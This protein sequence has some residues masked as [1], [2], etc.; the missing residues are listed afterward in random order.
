MSAA[1]EL[2]PRVVVGSDAVELRVDLLADYSPDS[3]GT[4]IAL[5]R[6]AAQAPIIFTVRTVGQ[7][8]KF[9]DEQ[10]DE[11]LALYRLAARMAVE[12]IDVEVTMP[13][14]VMQAVASFK[15]S[16]R[17][18]ASHHDPQGQLSWKNGSWMAFY[19][20]A[21]Q[22]GDIIK[23]CGVAR[24]LE[25]NFGLAAFKARMLAAHKTPI[26]ALNMGPHGRLSRVLNGFL[27]PVSHPDLPF[28][29]A[30]GQMS[31]R[32]IREALALVASWSR[33]RSRCSASPLP[34]RGRR[35]STTAS[36]ATSGFRTTTRSARRTGP[37]TCAAPSARPTLAA[38]P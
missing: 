10:H 25:D 19:N 20:R 26:I 3:V 9:P 15:G 11:A 34:S 28:K 21:L 8:G 27:T 1:L 37:R 14:R 29:A 38:R 30:P 17:I 7:G 6:S 32:E 4:Q 16:S 2:L 12:Y 24:C 33:A 35:R 5:L 31:A 18:I 13:D 23:L 36:S 22:H